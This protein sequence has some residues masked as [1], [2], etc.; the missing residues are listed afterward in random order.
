MVTR[1][2]VFRLTQAGTES[3]LHPEKR[4]GNVFEVDWRPEAETGV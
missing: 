4:V 3:L 2:V 1:K